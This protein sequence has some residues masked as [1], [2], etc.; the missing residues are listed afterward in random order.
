MSTTLPARGARLAASSRRLR[1]LALLVPVALV[2]LVLVPLQA[3]PAAA[4]GPCGPPVVNV[5]ACEN[6]QPGAA[7]STWQVTGSG[8]ATIQGFATSMSVNQGGTVQFKISTPAK[9]YH[10]DIFRMGYYQGKGAQADRAGPEAVRDPS[11]DPARVHERHPADRPHRLRQLG[12]LR[13]VGGPVDGRVGR[14]HRA[15]GP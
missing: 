3:I 2:A 9:A 14:L 6:T 8:D 7:A 10:F 13:V 12:G 11:A 15:P 4:A 1:R 5:I